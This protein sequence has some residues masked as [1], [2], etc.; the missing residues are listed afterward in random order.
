[1]KENNIAY[2]SITIQ[3]AKYIIY[4]VGLIFTVLEHSLYLLT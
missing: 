2:G 4:R 1:M 3:N